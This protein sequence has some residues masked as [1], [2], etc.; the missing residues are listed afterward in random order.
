M[1]QTRFPTRPVLLVDNEQACLNRASLALNAEGINN[2]VQCTDSR[3]V[4][5]MLSETEFSVVILDLLMPE[6]SGLDLLPLIL[7]D[8]PEVAV[9][10][11]TAVDRAG[12]AAQCL[13]NGA[14][15]YLVK[16]END[17]RLAAAVRRGIG[18]S[19][20]L[21]ENPQFAD[22]SEKPEGFSEIIT[23]D[24][25]MYSI[26]QYVKTIAPTD[27]P[28]LITGETGVGK[29]LI[30][31]AIHKL[32]ARKGK[33]VPVNVA[34]LDDGLFSD[35]LFGHRSGAF[36]NADS[37][38]VG[39]I[40]QASNGT[41]F[42]DEIGDLHTDSQVKLL[43]LF[44]GGGFLPLG[45]DSPTTSNARM[46]LATNREIQYLRNSD[47][48]RTDLYHRLKSYHIH[49]PPLRERM[50]DIPMLV[51]H[52]LDRAAKTMGKKT[53]APPQELFDLLGAYSFPGNVRELKGMVTN[54]VS[55]HKGG[56][57]ST[58][59]FR[60]DIDEQSIVSSDGTMFQTI[61]LAEELS[62]LS[63]LPDLKE[64]LKEVEQMIISEALKR[65][66]GNQTIAA[67]LLNMSRHALN[68]RL[69][70]AQTLSDD[71]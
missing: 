46:V 56:K 66:D 44:E 60:Q 30:A 42:L 57:L 3:E 51:V 4:M 48:F 18:I 26:F 28:V 10:V 65:A 40:E 29:E 8:F 24:P 31:S 58:E 69:I 21:Y 49:L 23:Q 47:Y 54:A 63:I 32:S 22:T 67:H 6:L 5:S 55:R 36:T 20:S 39:L 33:Y 1:N 64:S 43:R 35:T 50:G 34:G 71:E 19:D 70:R 59:S 14:F 25:A 62:M 45:E 16:S 52:F 15:D 38:R 11:V 68:K 17:T 61:G 12:S 13:N 37:P 27:F 41:L 2:I 53:P 9:A 7:A